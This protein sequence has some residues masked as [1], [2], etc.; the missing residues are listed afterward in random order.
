[1]ATLLGLLRCVRVPCAPLGYRRNRDL[2]TLAIRTRSVPSGRHLN[3]YR[4]HLLWFTFVP[5]IASA[6]FYASNG[7][8]PQ[9][10][11]AYIDCLYMCVSAICV[12]GLS[13]VLF[14]N[15]TVWQEVILGVSLLCILLWSGE[16]V[17]S[18]SLLAQFLM[19]IGGISFVSIIVLG[20]RRCVRLRSARRSTL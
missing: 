5:L 8:S 3:F 18:R 17:S 7:P 1:M 12:T 11:I 10:K 14:V 4:I 16:D 6:I 20:I 9:N 2:L 19:L 15:L 13:T